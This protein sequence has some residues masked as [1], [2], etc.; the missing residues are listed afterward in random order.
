MCAVQVCHI[1]STAVQEVT[2]RCYCT[3]SGLPRYRLRSNGQENCWRAIFRPRA[4]MAHIRQSRPDSGP[5][6]QVKA[7]DTVQVFPSSLDSGPGVVGGSQ[8]FGSLI[9][10]RESQREEECAGLTTCPWNTG[11]LS[12]GQQKYGCLACCLPESLTNG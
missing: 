11:W 2:D 1:R 10:M 7:L 6:V 4:N 3:G 9:S 5:G 12:R 8:T